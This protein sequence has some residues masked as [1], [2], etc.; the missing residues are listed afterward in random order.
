MAGCTPPLVLPRHVFKILRFCDSAVLP[1]MDLGLEDKIAI[2]TGSTK[3][4]GFGIARALVEE[5]CRVTICARGEA[6]L[7]DAT[8]SLRTIPGAT[9]RVLAVQADLSTEKGVAD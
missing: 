6:G 7:V 5:G 8:A 3:G 4:L 1:Y 9:E 2:V